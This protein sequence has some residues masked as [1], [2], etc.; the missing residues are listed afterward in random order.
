MR[1]VRSR[2]YFEQMKG[3]GARTINDADLQAVTPGA[4]MKERFVIVDAVGVTEHPFVDAAPLNRD[5]GISLGKLLERAATFTI[6]EDEVATLASRLSRLEREVSPKESDELTTLAGKPL[7]SIIQGLVTIVD[8]DVLARIEEYAPKNADGTPDVARA[9]RTYLNEIVE[10]LAG[11]A[12][13]RARLVEIRSSHDRIID[14]VSKDVLLD[15]GGVI[16]YDKCR[17]VITS[18]KGFLE[19]NKDEITL[20]Q[21]LYSQDKNAKITF[22][23]LRDLADTHRRTTT[24]VDH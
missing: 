23:E 10:P 14:E 22:A 24:I 18:W 13:L 20:L 15:A 3:R 5:K 8:P 7:S 16:D 19:E 12:R 6:G 1:D 2:T 17:E 4:T 9:M 11:N 21:I